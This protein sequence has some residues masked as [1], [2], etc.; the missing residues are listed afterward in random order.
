MS[1]TAV[2]TFKNILISEFMMIVVAFTLCIV[3]EFDF[4][5]VDYV[6]LINVISMF[7]NLIDQICDAK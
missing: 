3:S 5:K 1:S 4:M 6:F 7:F 2:I